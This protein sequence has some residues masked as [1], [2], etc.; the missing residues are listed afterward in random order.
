MTPIPH[1]SGNGQTQS[2]HSSNGYTQNPKSQENKRYR[3]S[4]I[5][6]IEPDG[7][8]AEFVLVD[9][10]APVVSN[11][12]AEQILSLTKDKKVR[13]LLEDAIKSANKPQR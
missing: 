7:F 1:K 11:Q 5:R 4:P 10:T 6:S 3:L 13:A 2:A 12:T 8:E 9:P